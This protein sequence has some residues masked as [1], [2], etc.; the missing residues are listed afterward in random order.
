MQGNHLWS[1]MTFRFRDGSLDDETTTFTQD[2]EFHLLTDHHVQK[3]PSFPHPVDVTIDVKNGTITR[4]SEGSENRKVEIERIN[5]PP[6]L[7]NGLLLDMIKNL[8]AEAAETRVSMIAAASKSRI[9]KLLIQPE[10][11]E[12]FYI[13]GVAHRA[14]KYVIKIELGGI[15]GAIAPIVGQKP[16]DSHVWIAAGAPPAMLRAESQFYLNGP[17]WTVELCSPTWNSR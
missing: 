10:D 6:D 16:H 3:G 11:D 7:S 5:M 17:M 15:A 8:P 9:V 12:R 4:K 2:S 14:K 1:R 13:A